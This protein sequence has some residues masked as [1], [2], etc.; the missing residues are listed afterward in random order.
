MQHLCCCCVGF[1]PG[2]FALTKILGF[3][4]WTP[5]LTQPQHSAKVSMMFV[6]GSRRMR[7]RT[8]S[9]VEGTMMRCVQPCPTVR[10]QSSGS[11]WKVVCCFAVLY[12]ISAG[13]VVVCSQHQVHAAQFAVCIYWR[14]SA[15]RRT[16]LAK[17]M[18]AWLVFSRA[19]RQHVGHKSSF[20]EF[21]AKALFAH[22]SVVPKAGI[23]TRE[24]KLLG[25]G[26]Q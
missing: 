10:G 24:V 5:S 19:A 9:C 2:I 17:D 6:A 13:H 12:L 21:F 26:P 1:D 23:L 16:C 15:S 22:H 18:V 20:A 14:W 25:F 11:D 4:E 7:F 8:P 3:S